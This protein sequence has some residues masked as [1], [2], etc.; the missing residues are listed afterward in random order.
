MSD[1]FISYRRKPSAALANLIQRELRA[2]YRID[3]YLDTTRTDSTRVQ[4]P[5]RLMAA[6][7]DAPTFICLLG[8]STLNSAWVRKEIWRAYKLKKYCI[9]VFQ[10][11]Y[12]PPTNSDAAIDYLLNFD[13]VHILDSKGVYIDEAIASIAALVVRKPKRRRLSWIVGLAVV[14]LLVIVGIAG[15][16]LLSRGDDEDGGIRGEITDTPETAIANL[17]T[18]NDIPTETLTPPT[19]THTPTDVPPTLTATPTH[20][21]TNVPPTQT[22]T[23]TPLP[24]TLSPFDLAQAGV[25]RNANWT[26]YSQV[27]GKGVEMMLVPAG[28]FTMGSTEAEIDLALEICNADIGS[29]LGECERSWFEQEGPTSQQTVATFWIDRTEVTRAQYQTCIDAGVCERPLDSEYSTQPNQPINNVTWFNA[30]DYCVWRGARLPTEAEWEYAA[31]GP[32]GLIYPWGNV[33]VAGNVADYSNFSNIT[34]VGSRLSGASWVGALD[35]SGNVWEWVG[36]E[37]R[38]YPYDGKDGRE[39]LVN[40]NRNSNYPVLR[41]GSLFPYAF[42]LRAANRMVIATTNGG[43]NVGLRCALSY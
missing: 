21:A 12:Q 42:H 39:D 43:F 24:A 2:T 5:D 19:P 29:D 22:P 11:S 8:D 32:E 25:T 1:A 6:I 30:R 23:D 18:E 7:G 20:T 10:E 34:E 36:S 33:F 17:P 35:M 41:G 27:D 38:A 9:P 28:T 16:I 13:G 3:A 14:G 31:R 4:F 15:A 37:Y 40:I 26:P